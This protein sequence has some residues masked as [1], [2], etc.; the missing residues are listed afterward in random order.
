[1]AEHAPVVV[2]IDGRSGAGKSTLATTVAGALGAALVPCDDFFAA[3]ITAI[4]WDR[5]TPAERASQCLEWHRLR[6]DVIEPLR[7]GRPA[8]WFAFDFAAGTRPDGSF[9]MQT[10]PSELAPAPVI[11]LD[12]AY[13]ARP[14]LADVLDLAI[15]VEAPAGIRRARLAARE[16]P[17]FL[18]AWHARW[19]AAED[20]Y[21]GRVRP[22]AT[23][24]L[25]FRSDGGHR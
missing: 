24:D 18:R 16:A 6:Q 15:L 21:F 11:V 20:H 22:S 1:M 23:F 3:G 5:W 25:V 13:S 2:A 4:E 14:E 12:G 19:D 10:V 17:E 9:P 7:N 8:R